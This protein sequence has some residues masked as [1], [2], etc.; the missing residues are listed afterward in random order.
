MATQI[1]GKVT[2]GIAAAA[3]E[4]RSGKGIFGNVHCRTN[5]GTAVSSP[6]SMKR[7]K[8]F[9]IN[10]DRL[11]ENLPPGSPAHDQVGRQRGRL[12]V[13]KYFHQLAGGNPSLLVYPADF[14]RADQAALGS[15]FA[16]VVLIDGSV[17][18]AFDPHHPLFCHGASLIAN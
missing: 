9:S 7:R 11:A 1:G 12:V 15:P 3:P 4:E 13:G 17:F 6:N 10:A 16:K 5:I 18:L 8:R 2:G 14:I